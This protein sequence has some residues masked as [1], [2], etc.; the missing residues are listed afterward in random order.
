MQ[1]SE[2]RK[3]VAKLTPLLTP[4]ALE[5]VATWN[6]RTMYKAGKAIQ[7]AREMKNYK[8]GEKLQDR[9]AGT[10]WDKLATVR[11]AE[12]FIRRTAAVLRTHRGWSPPYWGCGPDVGTRGTCGTHRLGACHLPHHH[13]QVYHQEERHQAE[14]HPAL[15]SH[16]WCGGRE[17]MTSINSYKQSKAPNHTDG[18]FQRQDRNGQHGLREHLC[19]TWTGTDEWKWW[20]LCRP[21]RPEPT[22]DRRQHLPTQAHP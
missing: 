17:K 7:V 13:S 10:E 16:Q 4:R 1:C 9:S 20:A 2:S 18:R 15:C 19:Y 22:G 3:E 5:R 11:T 21:V 8:I 14:H 12:T 6:I